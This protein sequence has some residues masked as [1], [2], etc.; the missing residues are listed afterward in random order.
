MTPEQVK[1]MVDRFLAWQLLDNFNPDSGITFDRISNKGNV[2]ESVRKPG[3]T[4]LFDAVQA[5]AMVLHMIEGLPEPLLK[6]EQ[7]PSQPKAK[8]SD[9]TD[10]KWATSTA[11]NA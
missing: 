11:P 4:N 1:Y 2:Y 9:M 7:I 3:G 5:K 8:D 6:T 10:E